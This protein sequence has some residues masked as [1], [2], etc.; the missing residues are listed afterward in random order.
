MDISMPEMDGFQAT[1]A[2]RNIEKNE[3][4]KRTPIIAVTAH[5]MKKDKQLC[6]DNDMDDYLSK[7]LT[8]DKLAECLKSWNV[9]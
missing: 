1:K 9:F 7:P 2:I 5:A 6:L 8:L 3:G 4:L